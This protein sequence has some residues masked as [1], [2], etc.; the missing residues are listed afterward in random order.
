MM[1]KMTGTSHVGVE[2]WDCSFSGATPKPHVSRSGH[3]NSRWMNN[4]SGFFAVVCPWTVQ[5]Q[6]RIFRGKGAGM[7]PGAC[8]KSHVK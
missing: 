8:R 2:I 7:S 5:N 3:I 1:P 4:P 6:G